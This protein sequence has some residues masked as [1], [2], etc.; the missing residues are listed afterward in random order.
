M[1][2]KY[3]INIL[4]LSVLSGDIIIHERVNSVPYG[5]P[6]PIKAFL[7]VSET[8]VR[9][10]NLLYR[11]A[12]NIEYIETPMIQIGRSVYQALIP[13]EFCKREFLEY[14]LL[15]EMH[16]HTRTK[17]PTIDADKNPI[18]IQIDLIKDES[19]S[20]EDSCIKSSALGLH[21][22]MNLPTDGTKSLCDALALRKPAFSMSQRES[23]NPSPK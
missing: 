6:V 19:N 16:H 12:G 11:P 7:E 3:F 21:H 17:F 13:E 20:S 10:F 18:R 14:Y 5:V 4:L 8:D 1:N 9:Q 23:A 15:L 2:N 22:A